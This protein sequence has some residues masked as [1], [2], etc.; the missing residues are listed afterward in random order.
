MKVELTDEEVALILD[1]IAATRVRSEKGCLEGIAKNL[2]KKTDEE[3]VAKL[4]KLRAFGKRLDDLA[5]KFSVSVHVDKTSARTYEEVLHDRLYHGGCCSSHVDRMGCACL[6]NAPTL[7]APICCDAK[8]CS[9][10][11]IYP[12]AGFMADDPCPIC[13]KTTCDNKGGKH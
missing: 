6:D 8:H 10:R 3:V 4:A 7:K 9:K 1:M 13:G 11:T 12:S 5:A 2:G